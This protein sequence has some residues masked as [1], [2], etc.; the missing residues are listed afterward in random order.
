MVVQKQRTIEK[1]ISFSGTGLHTGNVCNLVF[2]PAPVNSGIQLVRT[3]R[4]QSVQVIISPD[5]VRDVSRGTTIGDE[6]NH[7]HTT[8][9]ILAAISGL[10][11]DNIIVE[12]DSSEAPVAD[13]SALPFVMLLE[14]AGIVEQEAEKCFLT[15]NKPVEFSNNDVHIIAIPSDELR[16]SCTVDYRH[17]LVNSQYF[18]V[19]INPETFKRD[20]APARTF[21]FDYEIETLKKKGLAKGGSLDNAIVIGRDRIHSKEGLRFDNE[22][23]RHK[24]L[25]LMGDICLVGR[26]MKMH[27]VAIRCGHESNIQFSKL[28]KA[29]VSGVMERQYPP[30]PEGYRIVLNQEQIKQYIPHRYPFL[31]LDRIVIPKEDLKVIGYKYL[32]GNEDFFKGHFPGYPILPGV[33]AVEAMAQSTC[34]LFLSRPELQGK[35]A[36]FMTIDGVKFRRPMFPGDLLEMKIEVVRARERGGKAVGQVYVDNVLTC[37]AEF[38]FSVVDKEQK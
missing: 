15:I 26:P 30:L 7:I 19:A 20:L 11:I 8:E 24:I 29:A 18:S 17:P 5:N 34:V 22:F 12:I 21:C 33:I 23:V 13:G 10:G 32:T 6:D 2:K 14:K 35:L 16:I 4:G 38:M 37:E 9:H 36:F 1:E 28:L 25:D 27:V 3:K 31:F